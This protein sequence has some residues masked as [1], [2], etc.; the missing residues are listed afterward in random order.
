VIANLHHARHDCS[1]GT[2]CSTAVTRFNPS[3]VED[4]IFHHPFRR[5]RLYNEIAVSMRCKITRSES[6]NMNEGSGQ[7]RYNSHKCA[8]QFVSLI[9]SRIGNELCLL[10]NGHWGNINTVVL[11]WKTQCISF[12]LERLDPCVSRS[13]GRT[14]PRIHVLTQARRHVCGFA[15]VKR[16]SNNHFQVRL[17]LFLRECNRV[18]E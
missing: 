4:N 16:S 1:I 13:H 6:L 3:F 7:R 17:D 15:R 12:S 2:D 14:F 18:A 9:L 11:A 5:R 8:M 10:A